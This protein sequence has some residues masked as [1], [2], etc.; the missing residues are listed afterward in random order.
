[1]IIKHNS[2]NPVVLGK[3]PVLLDFWAQWCSPC[4]ITLNNLY[5]FSDDHPEIDIYEINVDECNEEFLENY[6]VQSLPTLICYE[7]GI[8]VWRHNGLMTRQQLEEKFK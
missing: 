8:E 1:M 6:H 3:T 4:K 2:E 7:D 5:K